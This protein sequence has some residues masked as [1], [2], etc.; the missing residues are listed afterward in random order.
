MRSQ[1]IGTG[2]YVPERVVTNEDLA[3]LMDTSDAWIRE[4]TGIEERRFVSEGQGSSHLGTHAAQKALNSA[5]L[6]PED[7]DFIVA[8]TLS[9]DYYFPGIGCLIQEMLDIPGV[10][11]LDVRNQ[12]CGF[13]YALSVADSYIRSGFYERILVVCS[14]VQSTALRLDTSGRDTAILFGDGAGAVVLGQSTEDSRGVLSSHLHADGRYA[15]ELWLD[16][17]GSINH[18]WLSHEMLD[19]ERHRAQMNGREV[20]KHAVRRFPEV[21]TEG[22]Q[23]NDLTIDDVSLIIPH[24]ANK[25]IT[26]AV[27]KRLGVNSNK[28][29]SNIERYGNTT[30]ASIPLALDEAYQNG[31]IN[32]G[33]IIVLAAFG[34][35]FT[36]AST[37]IRW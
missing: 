11:A 29:Y 36:W 22:L 1:I 27:A 26:D 16:V 28:V 14:E 35:G 7:I 9:P 17:P 33:D 4:R 34:S 8:A 13:I 2:S 32:E 23:A 3:R 18:P 25:R 5:G 15:K 30:S 6:K 24:Q 10:G 31:L 20:F 12:C 37:V 21:I 19:Q